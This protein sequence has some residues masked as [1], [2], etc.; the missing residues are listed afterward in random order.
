[1]A[2]RLCRVVEERTVALPAGGAIPV[3]LSIGLAIGGGGRPVAQVLDLAD[4]ALL[5]AK[6][7]GRNQVTVHQMTAA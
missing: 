7:D 4:Q 1:V 5:R 3:T 2:E 6:S